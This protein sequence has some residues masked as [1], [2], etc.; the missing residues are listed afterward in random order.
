MVKQALSI[1]EFLK[2]RSGKGKISLIIQDRL[3]E[4]DAVTEEDN[5]LLPKASIEVVGLLDSATL[6]VKSK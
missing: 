1:L 4:V 2:K 6:I 5:D 3:V